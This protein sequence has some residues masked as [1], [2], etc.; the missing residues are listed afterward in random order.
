[1][2]VFAGNDFVTTEF[3]PTVHPAPIDTPGM[4][5]TPS[6]IHTLSPIETGFVTRGLSSGISSGEDGVAPNDPWL[7][8]EM[9][10]LDAMSTLFPMETD[11]CATICTL[12]FNLQLSPNVRVGFLSDRSKRQLYPNV[13]PTP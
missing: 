10:I 4:M 7:V 8:S 13:N 2:I 1:M 5:Q 11:S 3:A 6:P 9:K 12:S